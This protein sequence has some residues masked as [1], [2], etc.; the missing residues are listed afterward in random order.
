[1]LKKLF[2]GSPISVNTILRFDENITSKKEDRLKVYEF[3]VSLEY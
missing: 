3:D 1:M 2:P